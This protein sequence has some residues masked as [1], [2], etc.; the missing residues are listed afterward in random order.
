M[1]NIAIIA[2]GM[3]LVLISACDKRNLPDKGAT[4]AES[5]SNE[6]WVVL[7]QNGSALTDPAKISTYNTSMNQDSIFVDDLGNIWPFKCKAKIDL[8]NMAFSTEK[9]Q[10]L[11]DIKVPGSSPAQY[12]RPTVTITNGKILPKAAK[13]LSGNPTDSIYMEIEFSDDPG[14]KYV[15]AG[16]AR[17]R[18]SEDEY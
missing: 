2:I 4:Y 13:S 6:W 18:F 16:S 5:V 3:C 17:T 7:S 1:R 14:N 9:T 12:Y 10:S 11:T 8:T 15:I